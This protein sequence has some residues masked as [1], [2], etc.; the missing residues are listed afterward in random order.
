M[1]TPEP[2]PYDQLTCP[3]PGCDDPLHIRWVM[4]YGL[5]HDDLTDPATPGPGDAQVGHWHVGCEQGHRVLV[6][7]PIVCPCGR[8]E[9]TE[10]CEDA[11]VDASEEL[12]TFRAADVARLREL[13]RIAPPAGGGPS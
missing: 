7:A 5:I 11:D 9:C 6:P 10:E 3:L 8:D 1:T 13:L 12:R 4:A 2:N